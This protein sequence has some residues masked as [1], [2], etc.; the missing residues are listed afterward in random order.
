M[1][2][3][4]RQQL[5]LDHHELGGVALRALGS[6]MTV[7]E[8]ALRAVGSV[9]AE[10]TLERVANLRLDDLAELTNEIRDQIVESISYCHIQILQGLVPAANCG[11][12]IRL[13]YR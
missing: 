5:V 6:T 10:P 9:A 3:H 13:S 4:E 7:G 1:P 11:T 8:A 2:L 12:T